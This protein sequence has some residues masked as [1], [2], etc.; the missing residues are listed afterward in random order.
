MS[1][2]QLEPK[3]VWQ[4]FFEICKVPRGSGNTNAVRD[5]L[6][7]R[8]EAHG[9]ETKCDEAGNLLI[10]KKADPGFENAPVICLQGHMD[11]VC[12]KRADC[13]HDFLKDPIVP[14][15]TEVNGKKVVM[16]TGT[17]LGADDGI[18]IATCLAF[19]FD[20]SIKCGKI[21][22]LCTKDEETTMYGVHH[23]T[24]DFLSCKYLLNLDS[25]DIGV[26]T[27]GSA[28][29]FCSD[30]IIP[31]AETKSVPKGECHCVTVNVHNFRG[32]HSGVDANAYRAN[33]IMVA[34]RI[35]LQGAKNGGQLC[36]M[37]GGSAHNAIPM[38]ASFCMNF[39]NDE[40]AKKFVALA[41]ELGKKIVHEYKDTDPHGAVEAELKCGC[42][43]EKC[44]F[45]DNA[46]TLKIFRGLVNYPS[47]VLRM[48]PVVKGLTE[49]SVNLGEFRYCA[50]EGG[51]FTML[52]RSSIMSFLANFNEQLEALTLLL[53]W[54]YV[55]N[56]D[57]YGGWEPNVNSP[58]LASC[59]KHYA[60]SLHC[61]ES[62]IK[63]EA[64]HAGLECGELISKYPGL[65]AVSIGPTVLNPHSDSELC[66]IDTV[67]PV[68]ECV[69][70]VVLE[71]SK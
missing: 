41:N 36:C 58:L 63:V 39:E 27:I 51:K 17:S 40:A 48:S 42:C 62:E 1:L 12:S 50:C 24:N 2:D 66:E 7:A 22:V 52:T 29:G 20:K 70:Q 30:I 6:K 44:T 67:A 60:E 56:R 19:V 57:A 8:A 3:A 25:E 45:V 43:C 14:R 31:K 46:E 10:I 53:G 34:A 32:G 69:K 59:R 61:K 15:L 16:A 37:K 21:E 11:M 38:D 65:E 71:L 64:I 28:G 13:K 23:M 55:G 26:I 33:A 47:T 4:E 9:L 49:S 35:A 5:M 54:K 18:G 68:Y